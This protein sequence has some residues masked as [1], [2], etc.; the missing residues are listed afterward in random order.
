MIYFNYIC[1]E[2]RDIMSDNNKDKITGIVDKIIYHRPDT[3]FYILNIELPNNEEVVIKAN[4]PQIHEGKP[5]EFKGSWADNARY[6]KQM[7]ANHLLAIGSCD[8]EGKDQG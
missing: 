7:T 1:I 3:G 5:Y 4:H 2:I 6:G 8:V